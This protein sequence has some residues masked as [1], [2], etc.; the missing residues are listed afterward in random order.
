[1]ALVDLGDGAQTVHQRVAIPV[2]HAPVLDIEAEMMRAIIADMPAELVT[3]G[4]EG[5]APRRLEGE[6]LP[7]LDLGLDPVN[8]LVV[9][10]VFETRM[11]PVDA[12]AIVALD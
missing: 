4:L 5:E 10:G 1:F 8:A 6:A 11:R 12:V 7:F 9:D 2:G 3:I